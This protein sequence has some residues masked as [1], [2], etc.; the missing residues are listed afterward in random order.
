MATTNSIN[1]WDDQQQKQREDYVNKRTRWPRNTAWSNHCDLVTVSM[2]QQTQQQLELVICHKQCLH[3]HREQRNT[4]QNSAIS[5]VG[6]TLFIRPLSKWPALLNLRKP[7]CTII[8]IY[9]HGISTYMYHKN[10]ATKWWVKNSHFSHGN[11]SWAPAGN[12]WIQPLPRYHCTAQGDPSRRLESRFNRYEVV[13]TLEYLQ[14]IFQVYTPYFFGWRSKKIHVKWW[15]HWVNCWGFI[16]VYINVVICTLPETNILAPETSPSQK[17]N[18]RIPGIHFQGRSAS[19]REGISC[20]KRYMYLEPKWGPF[21]LYLEFGPSGGF[22]SP[23][24]RGQTGSRH[25]YIM[26]FWFPSSVTTSLLQLF[27]HLEPPDATHGA[28]QTSLRGR[29]DQTSGVLN[30]AHRVV[31]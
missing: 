29:W 24:N 28:D 19:F 22:F 30:I 7:T 16:W 11:P 2:Q 21:V 5:N 20:N 10:P 8:Y 3:N 31:K 26:R 23:K 15:K 25:P 1:V 27:H 12:P 9:I 14:E 13:R 17:G 4:T 18:N 6:Q